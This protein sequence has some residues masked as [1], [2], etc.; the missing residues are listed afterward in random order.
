MGSTSEM[1]W[2]TL[3]TIVY[4]LGIR[5][6]TP[7]VANNEVLRWIIGPLNLPLG[8]NNHFPYTSTRETYILTTTNSL[9]GLGVEVKS[10]LNIPSS[11]Y[12]LRRFLRTKLWQNTSSKVDNTLDK[13]WLTLMTSLDGLGIG[14]L[15][16]TMGPILV[17]RGIIDH[18][19]PPLRMISHCP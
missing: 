15:G 6:L 16:T 7:T 2:L 5:T 8:M 13:G 1:Q 9:N 3:M 18:L 17:L 11:F 19:S 12:P 10:N 14:T 4:G